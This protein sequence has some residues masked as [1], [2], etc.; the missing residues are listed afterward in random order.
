MSYLD[1]LINRVE[2]M[3]IIIILGFF[4]RKKNFLDDTITTTMGDL[5]LKVIT[6]LTIFNSFVTEYSKEK[7][8]LLIMSLIVSILIHGVSIIFALLVFNK[9]YSVERFSTV[10]G[11]VGFFGLAVAIS[12]CGSEAAFYGAAFTAI[13]A[14]TMWTYGAFIMSNDKQV[15]SAKNIIKNFN[16]IAF[17][18]GL[19]FFFLKIDIPQVFKDTINQLSSINAPVC[20]LIIGV[21]LAHTK[22]EGLKNDLMSIVA[23]IS[24]LFIIPTLCA[25]IL[26]LVPNDYFTMKVTIMIVSSVPVASAATILATIYKQDNA[27]AARIVSISTLLCVITMPL[28]TKLAYLIWGV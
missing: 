14:I 25:L 19:V 11:N 15:I 16:V 1:I 12:V 2:I 4:L 27:K 17:L 18:L 13:N 28:M 24:R 22:L 23:I 21:G 6:P 5:M 20:G 10:M 3:F 26:K 9:K 8:H 7:L